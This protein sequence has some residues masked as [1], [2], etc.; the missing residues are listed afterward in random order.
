M[1]FFGN[2][3]LRTILVNYNCNIEK[4]NFSYKYLNKETLNYVGNKPAYVYYSRN[5]SKYHYE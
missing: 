1:S 2:K 4:G 3:G 5:F